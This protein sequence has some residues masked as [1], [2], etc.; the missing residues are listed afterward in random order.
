M[1]E[2]RKYDAISEYWMSY[3]DALRN[4]ILKIVKDGDTANELSHEVLMK[5]YASCCSGRSIRN[6]RSWLFQIAYNTCM[7]H[8]KK[9]GKTV[10]LVKDVEQEEENGVYLEASEF[11]APLLQLLPQKYAEPLRLADIEGLPQQEVALRLGLTLTA[12]K[13]RIQRGRKLLKDEITECIHFEVDQNGQL[14]AFE[15]KGSCEALQCYASK[16]PSGETGC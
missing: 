16:K 10:E 9:E 7:D 4:Y 5:V 15:V 14:S 11:I 2:L 12:A 6:I 3:K 1:I 8:F 13:T